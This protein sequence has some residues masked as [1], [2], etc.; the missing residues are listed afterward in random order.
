MVEGRL[1]SLFSPFLARLWWAGSSHSD[2]KVADDRKLPDAPKD[3]LR[4]AV[5]AM[6]TEPLYHRCSSQKVKATS[7][8]ENEIHVHYLRE[9]SAGHIRGHVFEF[10]FAVIFAWA[11]E[12]LWAVCHLVRVH[13]ERIFK[14]IP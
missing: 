3:V 12:A 4:L 1:Y 9:E 6:R 11:S 7:D 14:H 13:P 10:A 5:A 2:G 8:K